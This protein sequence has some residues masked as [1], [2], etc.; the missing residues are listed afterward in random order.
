MPFVK[1]KKARFNT[2]TQHT[3]QI[4]PFAYSFFAD[5]MF[6]YS[7]YVSL[8][9][10]SG[11]SGGQ[12][13]TLFVISNASKMIADIPMGFISDII[14]RR[15]VLILGI[16][17][18]IVFCLLC[19]IGRDF[20]IFAIAMFVV[21]FGNS[22]IWTHAWNYFYDY[23]KGLGETAS[24]PNFMGK[25]YAI[26]NLAIALAGFTGTYIFAQ[27][28]FFGIFT[29]SILSMLIAIVVLLQLP[30]YKPKTTIKTATSFGI[31]N[32]LHSFKLLRQLIKKPRIV[33]LLLFAILAD[34]MFIVFIDMNTALMNIS[35]FTPELVSQ[36]VGLVAF[37]RIFS[38]YF[39]G[40]T[41]KFMKFRRMHSLLLVLM[42]IGIMASI[43]NS[44]W[45]IF[46]VSLYLFVYPFF[47]TSIK[48]KI[49]HKV[50]DNTRAT[51]MSLASLFVSIFAITFNALIGIVAD[52]SGYFSAP[53]CIFLL[54]IIVL[55]V[56]RNMM[57]FYRLDA[58]IK[59]IIDN[60]KGKFYNFKKRKRM[61]INKS[62]K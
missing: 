5:F 41:E 24:F 10:K 2:N 9:A 56:V 7:F 27:L 45:V 54:V 61:L 28:G 19:L 30:N 32:P 39:S 38:N 62:K 26:S 48:T 44:L 47:D 23:K 59:R 22:C 20:C 51:I 33:R 58:G 3:K 16:F 18:R 12:L 15:S 57:Y 8:F 35:G 13:A 42:S 14:S 21:G 37:I 6:Y 29:G 49:Q 31:A 43:K 36:I 50:D 60:R 40:K 17:F 25:F 52:D 53:I 34:T 11:F 1:K 4:L 55:F 46:S